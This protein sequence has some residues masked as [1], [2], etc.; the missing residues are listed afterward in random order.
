MEYGVLLVVSSYAL[1]TYV[2]WAS[3]LVFGRVLVKLESSQAI[4]PTAQCPAYIF[5]LCPSPSPRNIYCNQAFQ[6]SD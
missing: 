5:F 6:S 2:R 4:L 3:P 1:G